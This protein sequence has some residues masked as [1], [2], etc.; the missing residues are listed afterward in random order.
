MRAL[1]LCIE[2]AIWAVAQ[3]VH[4]H[5]HIHWPLICARYE[6]ETYH[7]LLLNETAKVISQ[8]HAVKGLCWWNSPWARVRFPR[9]PPPPPCAAPAPAAVHLFGAR[10]ADLEMFLKVA[11]TEADIVIL[12]RPWEP[13]RWLSWVCPPPSFP[14]GRVSPPP[15]GQSPTLPQTTPRPVPANVLFGWYC[16]L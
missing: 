11:A 15:P 2:T 9:P 10:E 7:G 16:V 5:T 8:K 13:W 6:C 3:Y 14:S 4:T 12:D 1:F